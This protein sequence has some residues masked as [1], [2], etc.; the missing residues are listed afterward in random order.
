M[1]ILGLKSTIIEMK[2]SLKSST[3]DLNR[4]EKESVNLNIGQL[5]LS[6]LQNR[7]RKKK[8]KEKKSEQRTE[9]KGSLENDQEDQHT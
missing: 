6:S 3:V 7:K 2:I 8:K 9:P 1:E 5:R 4:H